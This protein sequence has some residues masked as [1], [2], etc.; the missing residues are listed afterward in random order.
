VT[1]EEDEEHKR[2][3]E[4]GAAKLLCPAASHIERDYV[5]PA[6]IRTGRVADYF[7]CGPG[8][9][10]PSRDQSSQRCPTTP[11]AKHARKDGRDE[12][13]C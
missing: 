10:K 6:G 5:L 11:I 4:Q 13:P 7:D 3:R 9:A 2:Q 1:H 12:A 8:Y